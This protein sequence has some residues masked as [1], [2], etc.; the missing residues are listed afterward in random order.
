MRYGPLLGRGHVGILDGDPG[1]DFSELMAVV[2]NAP[3]HLERAR[4]IVRAVNAHD[5]LVAAL[6]AAHA[7][8]LRVEELIYRQEGLPAPTT[9]RT[10]IE[11]AGAALIRAKEG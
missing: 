2:P 1:A 9:L 8:L 7:E 3:G 6:E 10:V 11:R 4:R 5:G